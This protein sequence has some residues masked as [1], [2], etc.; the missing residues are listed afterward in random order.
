MKQAYGGMKRFPIDEELLHPGIDTSIF[1]TDKE[2]ITAYNNIN[3][4]QNDS[5]G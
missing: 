2:L 5:R 1:K 3:A 4:G